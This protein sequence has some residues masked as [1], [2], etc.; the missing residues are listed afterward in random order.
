MSGNTI[1]VDQDII[2]ISL[3]MTIKILVKDEMGFRI[4]SYLKKKYQFFYKNNN[5]QARLEK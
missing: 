1:I 4:E 2:T 5:N 3:I